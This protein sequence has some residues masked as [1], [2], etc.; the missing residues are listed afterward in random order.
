MKKSIFTSFLIAFFAVTSYSQ[1]VINSSYQN[2]SCDSVVWVYSSIDSGVLPYVVTYDWG[3][4]SISNTTIQ[5]SFTSENHFY[6]NGGTYIVNISVSDGNGDTASTSLTVMYNVNPIIASITTQ[7]SLCN[8]CGGSASLNISGGQPPYFIYW[9]NGETGMTIDNLCDGLYEVFVYDSSQ[10]TWSD[11]FVIENL[12]A[13]NYEVTDPTCNSNDGSI[14]IVADTLASQISYNWSTG[15]TDS[16]ISGL[17]SGVYSVT[18]SGACNFVDSL[19]IYDSCGVVSG[20]VYGDINGNGQQDPG[21]I[22]IGGVEVKLLPDNIIGYTNPLGFYAIDVPDYGTYNVIITKPYYYINSCVDSSNGFVLLQGTVSDPVGQTHSVTISIASPISAGNNFGVEKPDDGCGTISGQVFNDLNGDGVK[23]PGENGYVGANLTTSL[24]G[25]AVSDMNGNY[26]FNVPLNVPVTVSLNTGYNGYYCNAAITSY[27]QTLPAN[28]GSYTATATLANPDTSGFDFGVDLSNANFDVG[29]Y[30]IWTT[31]NI[32]AGS[33]LSMWMDFKASGT[34][35]NPC[36]LRLD[37]DPILSYV[38]SAVAPSATGNGFV[39]W[40]YPAGQ[41]PSWYCMNVIFDVDSAATTGYNLVFTGSY[42]CGGADA[43][44]YN[45]SLV[46]DFDVTFGP[47]KTS[48]DPVAMYS[49]LPSS[50]MP[51]LISPEDTV[52][53]FLISYQNTTGFDASRLVIENPISEFLDISTISFPFSPHAFEMT[54]SDDNTVLFEFDNVDIPDSANNTLMSYGFIQYN[55]EAKRNLPIGTIITNKAN[56][57]WNGYNPI[58]TN[59]V[60]HK[61]ENPGGIDDGL[62]ANSL[63]VY[64][65]P[66]GTYTVIDLKPLT[67]EVSAVKLMNIL[68]EIVNTDFSIDGDNLIVNV[69]SLSTGLYFIEVSAGNS[70]FSNKLIVK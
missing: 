24:G 58:W 7:S 3:D 48:N 4:G 13:I 51:F 44:A 8:P 40:T 67:E 37:F 66:A 18:V 68:G 25:W 9:G 15:S 6:V 16:T 27:T 1:L 2:W 62:P 69:E 43:C 42:G 47:L 31:Q 59:E 19:Y 70:T 20:L 56:V 52:F 36:V 35:T 38:S 41:A 12:S 17:G 57:A 32:S 26:S 50:E 46:R 23:D 63:H 22:G 28:N 21:E 34:I 49:F 61:V 10:C 65:N 55:I 33:Q 54:I 14:S 45:D 5:S 53:S 64:P 39:E 30:T 29:V 60:Q 11:T